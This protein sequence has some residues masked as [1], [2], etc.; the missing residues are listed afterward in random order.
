M[1]KVISINERG[2]LTLPKELRR[3]IG[4]NGSGQVVA[5]ETSEGILIRAGVTFPVEIYTGERV[6]EFARNNEKAL[7]KFRFKK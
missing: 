3:S 2:T 6:A 1:T 4:V 7:A 5:E